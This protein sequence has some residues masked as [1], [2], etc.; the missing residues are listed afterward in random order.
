[1]FNPNIYFIIVFCFTKSES[2]SNSAND[3]KLKKQIKTMENEMKYLNQQY[4][5][6]MEK[7]LFLE[8]QTYN[9]MNTIKTLS[10]QNQ[11]LSILVCQNFNNNLSNGNNNNIKSSNID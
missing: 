7:N 5:M 6:V 4:D 8:S 2:N 10:Q 9:M 11:E 1:M 3:E